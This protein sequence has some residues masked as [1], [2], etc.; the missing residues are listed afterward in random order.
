MKLPFLNRFFRK[1]TITQRIATPFAVLLGGLVV[2]AG[3]YWSVVSLNGAA[4]ETDAR[5]TEFG[6][7]VDR[8]QSAVLQARR[9][10][11]D[12]LVRRDDKALEAYAKALAGAYADIDRAQ[13]LAPMETARTRL[14]ETR[15]HLKSY[16]ESFGNA[17]EVQRRLGYDDTSGLHGDLG[18]AVHE[19]GDAIEQQGR[20]ELTASMLRM[21]QHEKDFIQHRDEQYVSRMAEE[22]QHFAALLAT[23]GLPADL[24]FTIAD[25][26]KAYH[27]DFLRLTEGYKEL[28]AKVQ[29]LRDQVHAAEPPLEELGAI[30]TRLLAEDRQALAATTRRITWVF[31]VL[32]L[33]AVALASVTL[34]LTSRRI[35][36]PLGVLRRTLADIAAGNRGARARLATGDEFQ[37]VGDALDSLMDESGQYMQTEQE[38]EMLNSSIMALLRAVNQLGRGDLTTA[39]PVNADITGALGDAINQMSE[40]IAKTLAQVNNASAQ[41]MEGSKQAR[42]VAAQSRDTVLSTVRG[43]NE[44]R[45]TIQ[46]TAKRIKRLGERSQEI[47][48][49]IKLIDTIAERTNVLALNANMQAAQAGEAGRG[50]MVVAAEVQRLAESA[51]QATDQIAKLVSGIQIETGEAIA[52]MDRS[53]TEV[54]E[55]SQLAEKG[56]AE[57]TTTDEAVEALNALGAQL[58][59]AV[60]SFKL[61]DGYIADGGTNVSV[62]VGAAA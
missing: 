37:A 52:T 8:I 56:A 61:P 5:V 10:E 13:D 7:L 44:I 27:R 31:A 26:M 32:L 17:V 38:N 9:Y 20:A 34:R 14:E 50:F 36:Q 15:K 55:G 39:A 48:G 54:V 42:S 6:F 58:Q 4:A 40:S 18:Q 46:E 2:T 21:R 11:K 1:R 59:E 62:Q 29:L 25:R 12:F 57:M 23:S 30:T 51:K 49:I 60:R 43:M 45:S 22:Q 35:T 3:A 33:A 19:M 47:G 28:A 41:V 24:R 16:Q 53:I